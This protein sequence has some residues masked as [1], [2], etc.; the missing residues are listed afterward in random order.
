MYQGHSVIGL[1]AIIGRS[2]YHTVMI[3]CHNRNISNICGPGQG[4]CG[5]FLSL[6]SVVVCQGE[7]CTAEGC[8]YV[9][10]YIFDAV[11]TSA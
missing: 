3:L 2:N 7:L 10:T 6:T 1:T 8:T 5:L 11:Y 9:C 4:Q